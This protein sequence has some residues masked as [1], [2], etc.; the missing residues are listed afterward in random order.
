MKKFT[1]TFI[2]LTFSLCSTVIFGQE[3][4]LRYNFPIGKELKYKKFETTTAH[5]AGPG[6]IEE[7][8]D[9]KT[10]A[11]LKIT[12]DKPVDGNE[13]YIF[14]QDTLFID[15]EKNEQIGFRISDMYNNLT[16]KRIHVV[17]TPR[18]DLREIHIL[19]SIKNYQQM[20]MALTDTMLSQQALI[21]PS[22]PEKKVKI[23]ETW[24]DAR[25]DTLEPKF[26]IAGMD[27]NSGFT[28]RQSNTTYTIVGEEEYNKFHCIK[29][30]WKSKT[31]TESQMKIG[32]IEIYNEEEGNT[33]G[34]LYFAH[35]EGLTVSMEQKT[36]SDSSTAM[37]SGGENTVMPS[38]T[39]NETKLIL[40]TT[41]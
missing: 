25:T 30:T 15:E 41:P 39:N 12:G 37:V 14:V 5:I 13:S 27:A 7:N 21:F 22:L 9:R 1:F 35:K 2:L 28:I 18:G 26:A 38:S 36:F 3:F 34:T 4:T 6:G 17:I 32:D 19:D 20:Q 33:S 29:L 10:E 16:N 40:I 24:T 11:I 8:I 23:G 31:K